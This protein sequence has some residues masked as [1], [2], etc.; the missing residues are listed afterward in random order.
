MGHAFSM[1]D[2]EPLIREAM[3][4][5]FTFTM[6]PKG[7]SMLPLIREGLDSVIL[8]PLPEEIKAGDVIL[9]KREN[10]QFVLHRVMKVTHGSYIMCGDNQVI[11]E[12]GILRRNMIALATGM[13]R[14]NK[15]I[16]FSDNREYSLYTQKI[17]KAKKLK[18]LLHRIK[19]VIK[20]LLRKQK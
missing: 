9:Y 7:T 20:K 12:K 16:T 5:N 2:L 18:N 19:A 3:E 4:K 11:F 13:I 1:K 14:E 10:G 6:M 17:L 15:E 8:S